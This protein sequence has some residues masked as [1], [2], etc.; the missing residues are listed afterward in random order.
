[1]QQG[2]FCFALSALPTKAT[3]CLQ[4]LIWAKNAG[5]LN[6][7]ILTDSLVLVQLLQADNTQD[8]TLKWTIAQIRT[9][10]KTFTACQVQK[11]SRTQVTTT[12]QL[13]QWCRKQHRD[14]G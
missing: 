1:M 5:Q 11:V 7:R 10:G 4:S 12:H 8:I 13:A 2:L 6:V 9:L 3:T 14:F